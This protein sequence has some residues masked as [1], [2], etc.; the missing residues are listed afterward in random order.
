MK[1]DPQNESTIARLLAA[2]EAAQAATANVKTARREVSQAAKDLAAE[3]IK[4]AEARH[5]GTASKAP[6]K[7]TQPTAAALLALPADQAQFLNDKAA[8]GNAGREHRLTVK[9]A[10]MAATA[11]EKAALLDKF[12]IAISAFPNESNSIS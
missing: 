5:A 3:A 9:R 12:G 1:S 11:S 2:R 4:K 8:F 7:P 6:S 10:F